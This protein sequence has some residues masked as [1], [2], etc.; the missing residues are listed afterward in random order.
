MSGV[1]SG[2]ADAGG[3][4]QMLRLIAEDAALGGQDDGEDLGPPEEY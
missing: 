3:I 2:S 1:A 4:E